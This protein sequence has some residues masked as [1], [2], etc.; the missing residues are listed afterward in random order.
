[1]TAETSGPIV[2]Q[3][4]SLQDQWAK[5]AL[6]K[7]ADAVRRIEGPD[8]QFVM[9][10]GKVRGQQEDI[11][12]LQNSTYTEFTNVEMNV[13]VYGN[14]GIKLD[15]R[16]SK[17]WRTERTLAAITAIPTCSSIAMAGGRQCRPKPQKFRQQ[18]RNPVF[19]KISVAQGFCTVMLSERGP[20]LAARVEAPLWHARTYGYDRGPSTRGKTGRSLRVT[21]S[22]MI[23]PADISGSVFPLAAAGSDQV[24]GFAGERVEE[25]PTPNTWREQRTE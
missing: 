14:T 5:A 3:L 19:G 16:A 17:A 24:N 25:G 1:M 2:D 6:T 18:C 8:Y 15:W 10:D 7:D 13:R 20:V 9:P 23:L 12:S 22:R 11:A 21:A 4:K